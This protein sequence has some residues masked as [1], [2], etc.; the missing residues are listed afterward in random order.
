MYRKILTLTISF[1]LIFPIYAWET[2]ISYNNDTDKPTSST[3]SAFTSYSEDLY[4]KINDTNLDFE[5][6]K[7]A[8]KG[9]VQLQNKQQLKNS[10]Y[11]TL[12]DMSV[13]ANT[14]RFYL[15]NMETQS[16]EHKSVVA[17]GEKSGLEYAKKFSNKVNSHQSSIGFYKTAE[18][19]SGKHGL[20]LRLD[21]LEYSN[22][23]ARE[24]AIVIH[25]AD[26]A[27][28]DFIQSNGRLGRSWGCPALPDKDYAVIINKIKEGSCVFVYYPQ[29]Q[30]LSKS[31]LISI[32]N[33]L[34]TKN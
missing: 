34:D 11:L 12:I 32:E 23:K 10:K 16:I 29:E 26:Y 4:Q 31:K 7:H 28:P 27:N 33:I 15:I 14:E 9:Y 20:S 6:F 19:Y 30:Y 5:A 2:P 8:L 1:I 13:S 17:H 22:N 18:T 21:G 25:S 3:E 24:R